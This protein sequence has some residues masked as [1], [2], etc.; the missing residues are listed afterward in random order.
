MLLEPNELES[1][2]FGIVAAHVVS[3]ASATD[4]IDAEADE[5]GIDML[6]VRIDAHDLS[7]VHRFER[8][9]FQLMD[10]L[11]YYGRSLKN[12][13]A[14]K[15][16]PGITL[17][18][19]GSEDVAGVHAVAE[20]AFRDY[21]GHFHADPRLDNADADAAYVQWAEVSAQT[22]D[23]ARPVVVARSDSGQVIGF[24]SLRD[25]GDAQA[26]IVLNAVHPDEQGRGIYTLLVEH[27][28][29]VASDG[30]STRIV[31][32][33]QIQNYA[34]QRVW[35]RLGFVHTRSVYT[36]HKWYDREPK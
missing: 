15:V 19:A 1:K 8:A 21:M 12:V 33:T 10:T 28:L 22:A 20:S 9:G 11:V 6:T 36:L 3:H 26:E 31:V 4:A 18:A 2:R 34:V 5:L 35:S 32:S 29:A 17:S 13:Q 16:A 14:P 25:V 7:A 30:G 24:L 27:S 23:R